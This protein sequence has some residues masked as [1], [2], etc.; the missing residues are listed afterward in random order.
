MS[1]KE[2]GGTTVPES[3]RLITYMA[4]KL[5]LLSRETIPV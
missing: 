1:D 4:M 2:L 3:F 5:M